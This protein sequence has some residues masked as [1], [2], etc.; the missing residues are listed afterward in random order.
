MTAS[1]PKNLFGRTLILICLLA[2]PLL[3]AK[4]RGNYRAYYRGRVALHTQDPQDVAMNRHS[5]ELASTID[6]NSE[7]STAAGVRGYADA[8]FGANDRYENQ[9][10]NLESQELLIRDLY[11]QYKRRRLR[12]RAGYQQLVWG[13]AF[14]FFFADVINPKDTREFGLGGDL[15]AQRIT[16]PMLASTFFLNKGTVQFVWIPAPMMNRSP[17][18]GSDFAPPLGSLIP[19]A[20]ASI[21]P[22]RYLSPDPSNW[23]FGARVTSLIQG[24]DFGLFFLTYQDRNPTYRLE[25]SGTSARFFETHPKTTTVGL[26]GTKDLNSWVLRFEALYTRGRPMNAF[27]LNPS[28]LDSSLTIERSDFW[29]GV[30]GM[31]YTGWKSWRL[32]LQLSQD[33]YTALVTGALPARER[34]QG[35]V[36]L[37]IPVYHEHT[38]DLLG[39]VLLN[40]GS[41]LWQL[42]YQ[43]PLSERL[44]FA[45]GTY[46]FAGDSTS[47]YGRFTGAN[48]VFAQLKGYLH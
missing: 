31:D 6:W 16:A 39:S 2:S 3:V 26:T 27:S 12:I 28:N 40:D 30:I 37:S 10:E 33:Y 18:M 19:G 14:G 1:S 13:E 47:G 44:D 46:L 5:L 45:L 22:E 9:V 17:S 23:E 25:V 41:S 35:S 8:A 24:W 43:V 7:W 38:L 32:S 21:V 34:T 11:L 42:T 48:R 15:E 29:Q 20:T 4:V 36:S